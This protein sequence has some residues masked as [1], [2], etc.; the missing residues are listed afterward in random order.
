MVQQVIRKIPQLVTHLLMADLYAWQWLVAEGVGPALIDDRELHLA[1]IEALQGVDVLVLSA[2]P[3]YW[4]TQ[5]LD[6][7]QAYLDRGGSV[8]YLGGNGLYWVTSLHPTKPHLM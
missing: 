1:G 7:L 4:T 5:M 3:E 2:H 6:A 8:I